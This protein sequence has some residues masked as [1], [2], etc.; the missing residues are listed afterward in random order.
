MSKINI[1]GQLLSVAFW[2]LLEKYE[3]KLIKLYFDYNN[4]IYFK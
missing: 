3:L 1:M 4:K 2:L